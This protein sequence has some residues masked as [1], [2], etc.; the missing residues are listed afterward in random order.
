M[1]D[2]VLRH[3]RHLLRLGQMIDAAAAEGRQSDGAHEGWDL[4]RRALTAHQIVEEL[5]ALFH[6]V[7]LHL[8]ASAR[9]R[10]V[11]LQSMAVTLSIGGREAS[12]PLQALAFEDPLRRELTDQAHRIGRS[13][14]D[15]AVAISDAKATLKRDHM[16]R[17]ELRS[18]CDGHLWT[19][20]ATAMLTGASGGPVVMQLYNEWLHQL[21]LLRDALLPFEN[22][23]D[24]PVPLH[25]RGAGRGLRSLETPRRQFLGEFLT[26]ILTHATVVRFARSLFEGTEADNAP[27]GGEQYGFQVESGLVLPSVIGREDVAAGPRGLLSWHPARF[28]DLPSGRTVGFRC[29]LVDYLAAARSAI[30]DGTAGTPPT[31][32]ATILAEPVGERAALLWLDLSAGSHSYRVELGQCLRG[33]RFAYRPQAVREGVAVEAQVHRAQDILVQPGLVTASDGTHLV[34]TGGN[35]LI[36][37]ALLGKIYPENTVLGEAAAWSEV[38]AAGKGYGSKFI[39]GTPTD[40]P[41]FVEI[42]D[43]SV[44]AIGTRGGDDLPRAPS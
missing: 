6:A 40:C 27:E 12:L 14:A 36:T 5:D 9:D 34:P 30:G 35:A 10:Q 22:W 16:Q 44:V 38:L 25:R 41:K 24:V 26:R 2:Y 7:C 29:G 18:H 43:P 20:E 33:Q 23:A 3:G 8:G 15:W 17:I 13:L 1:P 28:P 42:A 32:D 39:L 37:L 11:L 31:G 21:V 4:P 19:E